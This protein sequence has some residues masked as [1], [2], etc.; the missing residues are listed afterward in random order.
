MWK[1]QYL[2]HNAAVKKCFLTSLHLKITFGWKGSIMNFKMSKLQPGAGSCASWKVA[3]DKGGGRGNYLHLSSG[4]HHLPPK[5]NLLSFTSH[6]F[7]RNVMIIMMVCGATAYGRKILRNYVLQVFFSSSPYWGWWSCWY[8]L[9][10][11]SWWQRLSLKLLPWY[12]KF[13]HVKICLVYLS[14]KISYYLYWL[15]FQTCQMFVK[16]KASFS[17]STVCSQMSSQIACKSGCVVALIAFVWLLP[18]MRFQVVPQVDCLNG[19]KITL[20]AFVSLFAAVCF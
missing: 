12:T 9:W 13:C 7:K 20:A 3:G 18:T 11:Q 14:Y 6:Q 2:Q 4:N 17:F 8:W 15:N 16:L 19:C 1:A 10:W 5:Y